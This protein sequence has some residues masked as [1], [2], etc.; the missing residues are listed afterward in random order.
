MQNAR[1]ASWPKLHVS[2]PTV[3]AN[4]G[5]NN[6][7]EPMS[8]DEEMQKYL[9]KMARATDSKWSANRNALTDGEPTVP[10]VKSGGRNQ[11][12]KYKKGEVRSG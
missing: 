5:L 3:R 10:R 6:K 7:D 12:P 2:G 9:Q 1:R 8:E 11:L 4:L